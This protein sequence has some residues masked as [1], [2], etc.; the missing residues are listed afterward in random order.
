ML[1]KVISGIL[2]FFVIVI[3]IV[4]LVNIDA[5]IKIG[6]NAIIAALVITIL[7]AVSRP[8]FK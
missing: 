6:V 8:F 2:I 4:G 3:T 1:N 5:A 7:I